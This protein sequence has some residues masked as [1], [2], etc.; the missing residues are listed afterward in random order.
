MVMVTVGQNI[1]VDNDEQ[2]VKMREWCR[3]NSIRYSFY[4]EKP[5][6]SWCSFL[7]NNKEDLMAFKLRWL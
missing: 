5:Y 6:A 1:L 4:T 2:V 3:E 7:F